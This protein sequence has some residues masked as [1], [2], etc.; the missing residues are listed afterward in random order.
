MRCLTSHSSPEEDDPLNGESQVEEEKENV[1][2]VAHTAG[3]PEA[4][5]VEAVA[6]G[7][8]ELA[9]LGAIRNHYL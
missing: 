2:V 7:I 9:V 8:A 5:V 4:V 3:Q 1:V 6:A